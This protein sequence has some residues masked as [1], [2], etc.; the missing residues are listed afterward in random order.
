MPSGTRNRLATIPSDL[1][2]SGCLGSVGVDKQLKISLSSQM[3]KA[4]PNGFLW[5]SAS[6]AHQIEGNNKNSD[7]W[8]HE[9]DEGTPAKDHSG[10]ACNSYELFDDDFE[11]ISDSG[12]NAV[13]F[14][15]EWAR[16]EPFPGEFSY[17]EIDHYREM[18]GA[19]RDRGLT[20]FVTLHHFTN[21]IWFADKGGWDNDEAVEVFGRYCLTVAKTLGDLLEYVCTIN[22]PSI[23]ASVGYLMGYFPPRRRD[24]NAFL[25]VTKNLIKSHGAAVEATRKATDAKVGI[26]LALSDIVPADESEESESLRELIYHRSTGVYVDALTTGEIRDLGEP[27]Y[28]PS[29]AGT[30]DFVGIQYYSRLVAGRRRDGRPNIGITHDVKEDERVTQMGWP[31][32]PIGMSRVIDDVKRTE[33][34]IYV[35]ENGIATDDDDERVEYVTKHLDQIHQTI[36]RGADVRGYFY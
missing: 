17:Q 28:V 20:P 4:F 23:V 5:G 32:H 30:D 27:E 31:W 25:K 7:W 24:L 22:E 35:T 9:K 3:T 2:G 14:S 1:P 21:P 26:C 34:P 18:I 10:L 33:L 16:I 29:I 36:E 19:A 15:I 8:R 6:A 11:L 12:Q 13:R